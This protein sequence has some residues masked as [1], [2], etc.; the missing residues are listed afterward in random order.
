MKKAIYKNNKTGS[1]FDVL[2]F[3]HQDFIEQNDAI[4]TYV[5][6]RLDENNKYMPIELN[7]VGGYC[8]HIE[9]ED[10]EWGSVFLL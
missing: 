1:M 7:K 5:K 6:S 9:G 10:K 8:Y 3:E 2:I 4:P